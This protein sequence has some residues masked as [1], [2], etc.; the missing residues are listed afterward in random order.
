ML[1]QNEIISLIK[2][3][4]NILL[5]THKKPD[6]DAAGAVFALAA[7]LKKISYLCVKILFED[8]NQKF[9]LISTSKISHNVDK[10]KIDL[11][12]ILD[13]GNENRLGKFEYI[14]DNKVTI[15]ID[16]HISNTNFANY[17]YVVSNASS[18]CEI[19]YEFIKKMDLMDEKIA[20]ALYAGIISD[21]GGFRHACTTSKT[22]KIVS[23]LLIFNFPFTRIYNELMMEKTVDEIKYLSMVIN[24]LEII[25]P[26]HLAIS[27]LTFEQINSVSNKFTGGLVD[28]IKNIYGIEIAV[29][30]IEN[31]DGS[32]KLSFRSNYT[33]VNKIAKEFN[34]GGHKLAAGG[35]INANIRET[36]E[37]IIKIIKEN[38]QCEMV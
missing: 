4:K 2:N 5:L 8:Y 32:C 18:T 22:H 35:I 7:A 3:H 10:D 9:N 12:I 38:S 14:I 17:N 11:V 26:Y 30:I 29:M 19:I 1:I 16:H 33:D 36:K 28:F 13:C 25:K 31:E 37:K 27:F 15:N 20:A 23:E 24:N 6:G 34:G 21:T